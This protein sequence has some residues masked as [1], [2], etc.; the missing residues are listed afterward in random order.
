MGIPARKFSA[1]KCIG[2]AALEAIE[3][4]ST[5]TGGDVVDEEEK[6]AATEEVEHAD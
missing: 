5:A 1:Y 3:R 2:R 6:R 4:K